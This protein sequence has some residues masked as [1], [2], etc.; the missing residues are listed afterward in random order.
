MSKLETLVAELSSLTVLEAAELAK[1][2]EDKWGVSAAAPVAV[3]A[4]PAAGAAPAAAAE[5]EQT[6][7]TVVLAGAGD[8][9]I[10]V[11]KEV[12]GV[13]PDLGL[14]E[15]KDLVEG[16]PQTVKENVSK[17]EAADIKAKLE[18]AGATVQIK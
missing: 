15:A 3:A 10:N 13:R 12:R 5:E 7:F 8:K 6:E 1:L 16:A 14:K 17:A 18:A 9:K 11:I 4:A 2:L